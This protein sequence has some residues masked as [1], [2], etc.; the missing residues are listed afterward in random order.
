MKYRYCEGQR[1]ASGI[2]SG[3]FKKLFV[4]NVPYCWKDVPLES[5][6]TI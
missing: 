3:G 1:V 5:L 6:E 2:I 4:I